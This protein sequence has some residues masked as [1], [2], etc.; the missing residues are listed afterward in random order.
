MSD[1][2]ITRRRHLGANASGMGRKSELSHT[3]FVKY[4]KRP[5]IRLC[6]SRFRVLRSS[7]WGCVSGSGGA[8]PQI[9]DHWR[10]CAGFDDRGGPLHGLIS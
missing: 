1:A 3:V 8:L 2:D 7:M 4:S 10:R 9:S 6:K 5:S